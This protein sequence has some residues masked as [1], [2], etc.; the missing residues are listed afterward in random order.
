[1]R[2]AG[3]ADHPDDLARIFH[4]RRGAADAF[5]DRIL[6]RPQLP[7]HG[8]VDHD[9]HR[10]VVAVGGGEVAAGEEADAE[11]LEVSWQNRGHACTRMATR[12]GDGL[13]FDDE[14]VAVV[15]TEGGKR[16]ANGDALDAGN[17]GE[18]IVEPTEEGVASR[19]RRDIGSA[20]ADVGGEEILRAPAGVALRDAL[21]AADEEGRADEQD[22]REGDLGDDEGVADAVLRARCSGAAGALLQGVRDVGAR[23]EP[24]REEAKADT[25]EDGGE[26]REGEDANI[27]GDGQAG[28]FAEAEGATDEVVGPEREHEAKGAADQREDE[29]LGQ[30]ELDQFPAR[31]AEGRANRVLAAARG[32]AGKLKVGQVGA[33]D[34]KDEAGESEDQD[35]NRATGTVLRAGIEAHEPEAAI[36]V[37]GGIGKREAVGES[38]HRSLRG[39]EWYGGLEARDDGEVGVLAIGGRDIGQCERAPGGDFAEEHGV[40]E[41]GR[42]DADDGDGLAIDP[43][44]AAEDAGIRTEALEP[45]GVGK[46]DDSVVAGAVFFGRERAAQ[47]RSRAEEREKIGGDEK[48]AQAVGGLAR[49]ADVEIGAAHGGGLLEHGVLRAVIEEVGGRVCVAL[50]GGGG[51]EE[52]DDALGLGI[53]RRVEEQGVEDAERAGVGS[54]AERQREDRDA[55]EAG[56]FREGAEGEA[57]IGH[58]RRR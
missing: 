16:G 9:D 11:G 41:A 7:R 25:G 27:E 58:G 21:Q 50:A 38:G 24:S 10:F 29:A 14:A 26:Q 54:D 4:E 2:G 17:G 31:G 52:T 35:G 33:G 49:L 6:A 12:F 34:E 45:G 13:A 53:R 55:R 51:A 5:A 44:R 47:G 46:N 18:A 19:S 30:D 32:V 20:Q 8:F 1:V 22:E 37:R 40:V 23:S 28:G 36:L 43:E 39:G 56:G 3:V 57:Q 15:E 48:A 42:H